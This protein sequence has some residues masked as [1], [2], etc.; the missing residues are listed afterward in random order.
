MESGWW[1]VNGLNMHARFETSLAPYN[2]PTVVLVH[3]LGASHRYMEPLIHELAPY[4]AVFAL[5]LP[6]FGRSE[7]P[8]EVFSISQLAD[9]LGEWLKAAHLDRPILFGHSMGC[10]VVVD[11]AARHP[12]IASGLVLEA[13]TADKTHRTLWQQSWRLAMSG[14]REKTGGLGWILVRDYWICGFRRFSGTVSAILED[15][16]EL[17]LPRVSG[18]TLVIVGSRDDLVPVR[19]AET[20]TNLLPKGTLRIVPKASHAINYYF[21]SESRLLLM[22]FLRHERL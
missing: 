11:L 5:D 21:P 15:H 18:P 19:W 1:K 12:E 13:P 16:I 14:W 2:A 4:V 3:G 17:K 8:R 6:G 20:V 22:D 7:K 10:Q 9:S